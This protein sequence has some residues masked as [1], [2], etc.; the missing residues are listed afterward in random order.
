MEKGTLKSK[1][2][3]NK[4]KEREKKGGKTNDSGKSGGWETG[5]K[6]L[7]QRVQGGA[8][9]SRTWTWLIGARPI[10]WELPS[11]VKT[12]EGWMGDGGNTGGLKSMVSQERQP[13]WVSQTKTREK[14]ERRGRDQIGE[15]VKKEG[16][17][18]GESRP[19]HPAIQQKSG[20]TTKSS[21]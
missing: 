13:I 20:F 12:T 21:R 1:A 2:G 18:R 19:I 7:L 5:P 6:K 8:H 3:V 10:T 9:A 4:Q 14:G 15:K 16:E 11:V 17:P